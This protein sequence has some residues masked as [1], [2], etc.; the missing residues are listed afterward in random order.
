MFFIVVFYLSSKHVFS[1]VPPRV[2]WISPNRTAELDNE[3][4]LVCQVTGRPTPRVVWTKNG[5]VLQDSLST[6]NITLDNI[7]P[8]DGGSYECSAINIVA[9][10]TRTTLLNVI[11]WYFP[12]PEITHRTSPHIA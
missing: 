10:D 11:G 6:G 7:S 8:A 5:L 4:T 12:S 2:L 1:S 9:N 3:V